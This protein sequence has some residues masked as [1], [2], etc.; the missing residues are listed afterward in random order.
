MKHNIEMSLSLF[1]KVRRYYA[2]KLQ[3]KFSNDG[4]S[5]N[6]IS[7]L[8]LLS[9]N[10]TINTSRELTYLSGVSKGLVSRSVDGLLKK[11]LIICIADK[12]DKRVQRIELT[13]KSQ[14]LIERIKIETAKI[15]E[16]ILC[17]ISQDEIIQMENT[18]SK[19]ISKFDLEEDE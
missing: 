18:I 8:I 9:N 13:E 17:D 12:N 1:S 3:S 15:N 10:K 7:I 2:N 16:Q 6:E 4:L 19:I 5:M 14:E 11:G